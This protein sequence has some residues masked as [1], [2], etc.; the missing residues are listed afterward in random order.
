MYQVTKYQDVVEIIELKDVQSGS[1]LKVAPKRGGIIT[2][3]G[4]NDQEIL[5]MNEERFKDLNKSIRG[6]IPI[7]FP[8]VGQLTD[9]TYVWNETEY[10]M[11]QHGIARDLA[12][13]VVELEVSEKAFI[14]LKV[15][16]NEESKKVFPFDFEIIYKY[17]LEGNKLTIEQEYHNFSDEPMPISVGFHPYFKISDKKSL[18]YEIDSDGYLDFRELALKPY[19]N[20]IDMSND[21]DAKLFPNRVNKVTF[22]DPNLTTFQKGKSPSSIGGGISN[23]TGQNFSGGSNP[24]LKSLNSRGNNEVI[25]S[26]LKRK[27][28]MEYSKEFKYVVLWSDG[29]DYICVEPWTA[30]PDSLNT[31]EDLIYVQPHEV[32]KAFLTISSDN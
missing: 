16:S 11:S 28:S 8:I 24:L 1:W 3:F 22:T 4:V 19:E 5:Y 2:G 9:D 20:K 6:G 25:T 13:E 30:K 31:K 32:Y 23:G 26:T 7:L 17:H 18:R 10:S 12:W 14:K 27:I 15:M 29:E 21:A